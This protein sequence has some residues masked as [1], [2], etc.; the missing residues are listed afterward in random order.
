MITAREIAALAVA[1]LVLVSLGMVF[2]RA[3]TG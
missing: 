1:A 3:L 2:A